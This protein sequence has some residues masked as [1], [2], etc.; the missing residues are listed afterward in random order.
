MRRNR[1]GAGKEHLAQTAVWEIKMCFV[2]RSGRCRTLVSKKNITVFI[3]N[4]EAHQ[5]LSKLSPETT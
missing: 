2:G 3:F 4:I 5:L 1:R